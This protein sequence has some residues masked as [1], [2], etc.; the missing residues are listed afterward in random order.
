MKK[1]AKK[2]TALLLAV[3]MAVVPLTASAAGNPSENVKNGDIWRYVGAIPIPIVDS[4]FGTP[5]GVDEVRLSQQVIADNGDGTFDV[6]VKVQGGSGVNITSEEAIVFVLDASASLTSAQWTQLRLACITFVES[7]PADVNTYFGI[8]VFHDSATIMI[9]LSNDRIQIVNVLSA[10]NRPNNTYT[11]IGEGLVKAKDVLDLYTGNGAKTAIVVTDGEVNRPLPSPIGYMQNAAALLKDSGA[12]IFAVGVGSDYSLNELNMIASVIPGLKTIYELADFSL[13]EE[14]LLNMAPKDATI[15]MGSD[16]D[17]DSFISFS[18]SADSVSE[19]SGTIIWNLEN[20]VVNTLVYRIR[21]KDSM[22]GKGFKPVSDISYVRYSSEKNRRTAYFDI[23]YVQMDHCTLYGHE[24]GEW[25]VYIPATC[26][27]E[28][29]EIR[30]CANDPLHTETRAI[31]ALGHDDYAGETYEAVITAATCET[32]GEMGI[33]CSECGELIGTEVIPALGHEWVLKDHKDATATEDG[34]DYYECN[35]CDENYTDIIPATGETELTIVS[36]SNV[37]F[38]S[39]VETA[40][41]SRVW[42]L[43]FSVTVTYLNGE[44]A[45]MTYSINLNG[46]NANLDGKYTFGADHALAG[47]TLT[48]DIKGNGSNIKAFSIK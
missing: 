41:N 14:A 30:V 39:I 37:K 24:W 3:M 46:N 40:K 4:D 42:V 20:D 22:L 34:Y 8:V 2:L 12:D 23:P 1:R 38:I 6:E 18:G 9:Q 43:T 25:E 44:T 32:A 21:V 48:Y 33:Y 19:S 16:I 45:V 35:H 13:L 26:D 27:T 47:Y 15:T 17:F 7:Y 5:L 36:V 11:N 29:V 10:L 31:P 28:G